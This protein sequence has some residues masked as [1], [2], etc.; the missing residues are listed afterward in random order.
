P[1]TLN[2]DAAWRSGNLRRTTRYAA[3]IRP[4]TTTNSTE[5]T[6]VIRVNAS[7]TLA[8]AYKIARLGTRHATENS[9]PRAGTWLRDKIPQR[10][11]AWPSRAR[12]NSMRDVEKIPLFADEAADVSTTKLIMPA[13]AGSPARAN[14][15]TNGLESLWTLS[16]GVTIM[17]TARARM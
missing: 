3:R 1:G 15:C 9:K 14:I 17:M 8:P 10:L 7:M 12:P 16:H 13:A 5:E 6:V 11:G 4:H 2:L